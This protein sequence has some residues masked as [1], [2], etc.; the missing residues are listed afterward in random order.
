ML[1][2]LY[3]A[4][5]LPF[6]LHWGLKYAGQLKEDSII[7]NTYWTALCLQMKWE[8][9]IRQLYYSIAVMIA[10]SLANSTFSYTMLRHFLQ[11]A[12]RLGWVFMGDRS[13]WRH[14]ENLVVENSSWC[15]W[16]Y[17][18]LQSTTRSTVTE[19]MHHHYITHLNRQ[20]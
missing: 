11:L 18:A 13:A 10:L 16:L 1:K 8:G 4:Q 15:V 17:E 19:I 14:R 9:R 6:L 12:R 20:R 5:S 3:L 2:T 7:E